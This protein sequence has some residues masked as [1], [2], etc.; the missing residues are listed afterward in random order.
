VKIVHVIDS[1]GLYGAEKVLLALV[2]QQIAAGD[3]VRVC[4]LG[5]PHDVKALDAELAR[6]GYACDPLRFASGLNLSGISPIEQYLMGMQSACRALS[7][8]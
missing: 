2:E 5:A 1:G 8:L 7:W 3:D 6:L 4:S